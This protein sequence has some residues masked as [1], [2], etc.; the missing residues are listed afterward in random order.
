[1]LWHYFC[2]LFQLSI[3]WK[4]CPLVQE[5][6]WLKIKYMYLS[7]YQNV[8]IHKFISLIRNIAPFCLLIELII[9]IT[10]KKENYHYLKGL[11]DKGRFFRNLALLSSAIYRQLLSIVPKPFEYQIHNHFC[12]LQVIFNEMNLLFLQLNQNVKTDWSLNF[13]SLYTKL[14]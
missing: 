6:P 9:I 14:S 11:I 12:P 1:M 7:K 2:H 5:N 4:L 13:H 10:N 8:H 3:D